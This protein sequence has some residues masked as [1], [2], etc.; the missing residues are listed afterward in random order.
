MSSRPDRASQLAALHAPGELVVVVNAWDAA[1]AKAAEHAGAR[2]V[3]TTSGGVSAAYGYADGERIPRALVIAAIEHIAAATDLPVTADLES[4][5]GDSP[6]AVAETVR[7]ALEAGAAGFN[8]EDGYPAARRAAQASPIRPIAAQVERLHAAREACHAAGVHD[9]VINAR[10]DVFLREIGAPERRVDLALERAAAYVAAGA[11]CVFPIGVTDA[12]SIRALTSGIDAP[13]NVLAL[14][15][16]PTLRELAELGV[17]RVSLGTGWHRYA[18]R[19]AEG[20]AR[21][22]LADGDLERLWR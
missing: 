18:M 17:R 5:Y 4:G 14:P 20:A 10:I 6:E 2:C 1:S 16:V 13:V 15:G 11:R 19:M 22:L 3:G 12:A 9:A 21:D 7:L 8:L